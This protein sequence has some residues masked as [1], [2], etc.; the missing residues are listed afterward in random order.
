MNQEDGS[1]PGEGS[2]KGETAGEKKEPESIP[3][4][5]LLDGRGL[6]ALSEKIGRN[7][8]ISNRVL[9]QACLIAGSLKRMDLAERLEALLRNSA[10][11]VVRQAAEWALGHLD[12][13]MK[14]R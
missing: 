12:G 8:A 14:T 2:R 13:K 11:P 3:L 9:T 4:E 6:A 5:E 10:S 1:K 7:Y